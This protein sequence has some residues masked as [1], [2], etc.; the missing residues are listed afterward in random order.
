M[1]TQKYSSF[2]ENFD[3]KT[4]VPLDTH[5]PNLPKMP[6]QSE[7]GQQ[8]Y[9]PFYE[10]R[11]PWRSTFFESQGVARHKENQTIQDIA[12][13]ETEYAHIQPLVNREMSKN[14]E[15]YIDLLRSQN[16]QLFYNG[17]AGMQTSS[18]YPG[19]RFTTDYNKQM[20]IKYSKYYHVN[21]QN[22]AYVGSDG[23]PNC[24]LMKDTFRP[25]KKS[26][27]DNQFKMCDVVGGEIIPTGLYCSPKNG[28][29][30]M[31]I[32]P[33]RPNEDASFGL[34]FDEQSRVATKVFPEIITVVR[35]ILSKI[36]MEGFTTDKQAFAFKQKLEHTVSNP[37]TK[38]FVR[39]LVMYTYLGKV[40]LLPNL[41]Y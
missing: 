18:L 16:N 25:C 6:I 41:P 10:Y 32:N 20:D 1:K 21:E 36:N 35:K 2:Q 4:D 27:T 39:S 37:I 13:I 31:P 26:L 29:V 11:Q 33:R 15:V 3:Y 23:L 34:I 7:F 19:T 8:D 38:V 14:A 9:K 22:P 28:H 24:Q 5:N 17:R 30:T 12:R 40:Y